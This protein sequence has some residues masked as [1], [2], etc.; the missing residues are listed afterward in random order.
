MALTV[1]KL[2]HPATPKGI[3]AKVVPMLSVYYV[4]LTHD[5]LAAQVGAIWQDELEGYPLWAVHNAT[6]WWVSRNNPY[7]HRSP[8]PGDISSRCDVEMGL[9]IAAETKI[10]IFDRDGP[11]EFEPE[12]SVVPEDE[13]VSRRAHSEK[14]L[15]EVFP[16][17]F[18]SKR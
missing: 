8:V 3:A 1:Q 10:R 4:A 7:K 14:V 5:A 18:D 13:L 15:R 16:K 9:V 17:R 11:G 6:R 2:K 12:R